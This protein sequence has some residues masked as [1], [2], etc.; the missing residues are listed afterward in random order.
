MIRESQPLLRV[1]IKSWRMT[2]TL[3]LFQTNQAYIKFRMIINLKITF[4]KKYHM[5]KPKFLKD[6]MVVIFKRLIE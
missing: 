3:R 2:L 1:A 5:I 4:S 6:K